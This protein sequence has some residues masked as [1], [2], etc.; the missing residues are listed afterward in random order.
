MKKILLAL[1]FLLSIISY[2]ENIS[3]KEITPFE[4]EG[5]DDFSEGLA[6]V[7]KD[8]KWG[9]IDKTGK[10]VIPFEYDSARDFKEGLAHVWKDGKCTYII[11]IEK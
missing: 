7:M 4:Y 1:L 6:F 2:G 5:G 10:V 9:Y 8:G 11:K 3:Y